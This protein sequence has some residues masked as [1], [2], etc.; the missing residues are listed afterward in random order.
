MWERYSNLMDSNV[1]GC[2][3][4]RGEAELIRHAV[5]TQYNVGD[6]RSV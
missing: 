6:A 3:R 2:V 1:E 5:H 4:V